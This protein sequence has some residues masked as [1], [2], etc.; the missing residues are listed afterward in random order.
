MSEPTHTKHR[1]QITG[2]GPAV[3]KCVECSDP[4]AQERGRLYVVQILRHMRYG[5]DISQHV[6]GIA[7]I[8]GHARDGVNV[9]TS[10]GIAGP[11]AYTESARTAEPA[12]PRSGAGFP[13]LHVGSDCLHHSD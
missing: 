2:L 9:Q 13:A 4:G 12:H 5:R 1:H 3:S 6:G 7:A 8:A 10:E 11:A